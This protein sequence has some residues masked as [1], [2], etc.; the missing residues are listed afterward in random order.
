MDYKKVLFNFFNK[1]LNK[2]E[3]LGN[4]HVIENVEAETTRTNAENLKILKS[5]KT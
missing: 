3:Q 2:N 1:Y 4:K 5:K